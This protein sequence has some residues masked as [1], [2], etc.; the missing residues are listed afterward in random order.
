MKITDTSY[1]IMYLQRRMITTTIKIPIMMMIM[2]MN[3]TL[4]HIVDRVKEW[5]VYLT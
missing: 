2:M 3:K 1:I 5:E 4:F